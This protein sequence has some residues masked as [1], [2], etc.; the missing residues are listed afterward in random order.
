MGVGV[1]RDIA[2]LLVDARER[3]R[4]VANVDADKEVRRSYVLRIQ[5]V[6]QLSR[7]L[8]KMSRV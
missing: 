7:A 8:I 5:K 4:G 2:A 3:V 6:E 1:H